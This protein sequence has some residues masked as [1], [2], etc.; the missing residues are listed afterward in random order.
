MPSGTQQIKLTYMGKP[1]YKGVDLS[2][3]ETDI[4]TASTPFVD[5]MILRRGELRSRYPFTP[6]MPAPN[7]GTA[8]RGLTCFFD[9]NAVMHTVAITRLGI[10]QLSN[11]WQSIVAGGQNPW[12]ILVNFGSEQPDAQYAM[13]VLQTNLFFTNGGSNIFKWNG[14]TNTVQTLDGLA[15]GTSFSAFYLMELGAKIICAY[16]I[17]TKAGITNIFPYR[18]RWT[19]T[20]PAANTP[21]DPTVNLGAG[22]NDELDVPD[23]I[24]GIMPLG[25]TGYIYRNNGITEMI[26]NSSGNG[27]DFDHLW[28]SDRGIGNVLPQSLAGYGPMHIFIAGDNA[29]QLTPNSFT[30]IGGLAFNAIAKDLGMAYGVI[31][32]TIIPYFS[33]AVPYSVYWLTIPLIN[34][35]VA[36][37][38]YDINEQSWTRWT[39]NRKSFTCK[40]RLVY[41]Q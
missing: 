15:D 29:Y 31:S 40:P 6:T 39:N 7:D 32:A 26:P 19:N 1:L 37:W 13:T 14:L 27:F 28:A 18:V 12:L 35:T 2:V 25:R 23:T 20:P 4:D 24:T 22:L 16:T 21:F 34:D 38:L 41:V 9:I 33:R 36:H 17:E 3:P 10:Y 5:N 30:A 8:T 11:N